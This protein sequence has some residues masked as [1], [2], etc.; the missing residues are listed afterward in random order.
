MGRADGRRGRVT[1]DRARGSRGSAGRALAVGLLIVASLLL[2]A[3]VALAGPDP[4][5]TPY[6]G[7]LEAPDPGSS[8]DDEHVL[9]VA[10]LGLGTVNGLAF[11]GVVIVSRFR[12][13]SAEETRRA[14]MARTSRGVP[15]GPRRPRLRPLAVGRR[16]GDP[17]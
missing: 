1:R 14:L 11:A 9:E 10:M 2:G 16:H 7:A 17:R 12:G 8:F 13:S 6:G 3:P 4:A 5:P 15:S